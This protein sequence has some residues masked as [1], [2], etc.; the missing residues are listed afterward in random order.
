MEPA[1]LKVGILD[2]VTGAPAGPGHLDQ[3]IRIA[4]EELQASGR[5]DRDLE[6]VHA[7][8]LGLPQG[9]AANVIHAY[10]ELVAADVLLIVGPAIGDNALV[11][12]PLA[13]AAEVPTLN[14][15]GT[16]RARSEWM[17]H[18]QVGSHEDESIVLA[19]HLH[20]LG[21]TRIGVAY[22]A[23]PIGRR[24]LSFFLEE[25]A[26]LGMTIAAMPSIAPLA[27]DATEQVTAIMG[28][29]CDAVLYLGLGLA[30]P[31]IG[32]G[33]TER[34]FAGPCAMNTAGLRGW[35]PS[36]AKQIDGF[37]YLDMCSEHNQELQ[38]LRGQMSLSFRE[39]AR[40]CIGWD[41]GRLVVEGLARAPERTRAGVRDGLEQIKWL[42]AAEG[43]EGTLLS[44][45][46]HDRGALH[47]RYLVVRR[48]VAGESVEV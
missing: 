46:N 14:W 23:S 16:E 31:A 6:L 9:T 10:E 33:L 36:F 48:W 13:D 43:H 1:P 47:G 42:P 12:T 3:F 18:L 19:R 20:G 24:Y 41:V 28:S 39:A 40:A 15:A 29:N 35:D 25:A 32:R 37:W 4:A 11:A 27:E 21:A 22:D 38:R 5:L 8:G 2:D 44:F 30:A 34:G 7:S 17:F 26:V 45:G